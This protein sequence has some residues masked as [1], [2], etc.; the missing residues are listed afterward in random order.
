MLSA[1]SRQLTRPVALFVTCVLI[2]SGVSGV[3]GSSSASTAL[4]ANFA[5]LTRDP[6][7]G[8][9]GKAEL[10]GVFASA[11]QGNP[12][13]LAANPVD[14]AYDAAGQLR[15]VSQTSGG[16]ATGRYNYD[17]AGNL[18][19]I[20]HYD[21]T[22]LSIVSM[23]PS[24][25]SAGASVAISGTA[26]A[27]TPSGNTVKFNGTAATVVSASAV[28][29]VVTVPSG[30]SSGTVTVATSGGTTTSQQ[31][32]T[33]D[34]AAVAPTVT[35]VSPVVAAAG[36]DVTVTGT[37]FDPTPG[38]NNV[39]F[40]HTRARVK[41]A[42]PT[43]LTVTVPDS[44]GAGPVSV[45]TAVG[46]ASSGVKFT[47]VPDK[48][49]SATIAT[50][51]DMTVD[52]AA[53]TV[54]VP[55]AGQK[56][57]LRF[58]GSQGQ[59]LSV[60]FSGVTLADF[61]AVPYSPYGGSFGRTQ[62][63]QGWQFTTTMF[64]AIPLP[65]LPASGIYEV[66]VDPVGSATGSVTATL[67]SRV[68][69]TLN[70]TGAGTTVNLG[71]VQQ[72][73][74]LTFAATAG[75][76]I[77]IG[78][79]GSTFP[80][81]TR[82]AVRLTEPHGA[83]VFWQ[84]SF[85]A[86]VFS[87]D[88]QDLDFT[89]AE[90]GTYTLIIGAMTAGTG[91]ITVTA[92]P[93]LAG[94]ALTLGTA[95]T[96]AINRPG[97]DVRLTF[98]GGKGQVLGADFTAYAFAF[99]PF[100]VVYSPDGSVLRASNVDSPHFDL[101]PLPAD[102]TYQMTLSPYSSTGS[103]TMVLSL[104]G[105]AVP[106]TVDGA[107]VTASIPAAGQTARLAVTTTAA[108]QWVTFAF[109]NYTLPTTLSAQVID[110][111][112]TVIAG[113]TIGSLSTFSVTPATAGTYTLILRPSDGTSTGSV[114]VT[115]SSQVNGGGFT[116][117]AAKNLSAT[118]V[119]QTT[120]Y[121]FTATANQR[122]SLSFG[123][124]AFTHTLGVA[125]VKPDG[126]VLQDTFLTT[127]ELDLGPVP[128][129]G[130]YSFVIHPFAET[131]SSQLTLLNRTDAGAST[132][133]GAAKTLTVS[134]TGWLAETSFTATAGERLSFGFT[135]WT[136][137]ADAVLRIRVIDATG[138]EIADQLTGNGF[139]LDTRVPTAG[140]YRLVL[141]STTFSTGGVA[142]TLSDQ[143][144][145]G[146]ITLASAKNITFGRAG[147]SAWMTYAGT[148]GQS[149]ALTLSNVTLPFYPEV[150][151]I[152]PGGTVLVDN[153]GAPSV[154]IPTLPATG[155]YEIDV[156][157]YSFTG[158]ATFRLGT[159]STAAA[160]PDGHPSTHA[161]DRM[162]A[163]ETRPAPAGSGNARRYVAATVFAPM[164]NAQQHKAPAS[165]LT[166]MGA[167]AQTWMPD[168]RN[169]AGADWDAHLPASPNAKAATVRAPPGVTAL[170][171]RIL[172]VD[173]KPLANITV[174]IENTTAKTD[175]TGQFLLTDLKAGH[176]VLR[177][178][179]ASANTTQSTFGL[180]D[181][182][183]DLTAG[184]TV[185]LP[186]PV[187]LT[188]LDTAHIVHFPS[189]TTAQTI[190]S[191][192]VIPGLQVQLP[193]GAVVRDVHGNVITALGITAIPVDRAPFPLPRS[194]VPVYFTVQPGSSYVFPTGARIVYPNYTHDAPGK[195]M[196][197]WH[198]DP[199]GK[200]WYVYGHGTVT[201]DGGQVVPDNGVEVYQF[202]GAM[203]ITPGE[204]PPPPTGPRPGGQVSDADPVDLGS[205]LLVD[206]HT[207]LTVNDLLPIS[208]A[209]TYQQSDAGHRT[210][211]IGVTSDYDIR[212]F[213]NQRFVEA[214]VVLPDGGKVH[215]RRITP[216]SVAPNDFLNAA[217]A[218]DPTPT[219]FNG[220]ILAW[221]GDGW[222][223]RL[224]NGLTYLFGDEAP[225]RA[226][227]DKFG[228]T[229]TIIRAPA[230]PDSDNIVRDKG[231][232]TQVTSP[233]GHWI[234]FTNDTGNRVTKAEDNSGR[235]VS[236]T[237]DSN[238]RLSTVTDV[239]GGLTTYS[240]DGSGRLSTIKDAR[241]TVYLTNE[242]DAAGRVQK[243]TLA[244][245][246]IYIIS[247][248]TD[249]SGKVTSTSLT[250]PRGHVRRL[251]FN[252]AG[253]ILTDTYAFG[254]TNAQTLTYT[255][256]A[257]SNLVTAVTDALNRQ[258]TYAYDA[259]GNPKT[260]VAMAGTSGAR[261][262]QVAYDGPY[263]QVSKIT[264]PVNHSWT[265]DYKTNG[266][267]VKV[268]DPASRASAV[269]SDE[270]GR[271]TKITDNAG[272]ATLIGY[273][274]G[275]PTSVTDPLGRISSQVLDAAGRVSRQTDPAGSTTSFTWDPRSNLGSATDPL[276]RQT[277]F[278]YDPNGNLHT[279]KD[280]RQNTTTYDYDTS[281][282]LK[283]VTDPL[284]RATTYTYDSNNNLATATDARGKQA[285]YTYDEVDRPQTVRYGVS[286]N[287]QESQIT[288][289]YDL[290]NRL[291]TVAD[292]AGG[293]TTL[294]PDDF[295]NL[296]RV[297]TP[298]GQVDYAYYADNRRQ[299]MTVGGQPTT[300]YTY[301]AD[302]RLKQLTRAGATVTLGYDT[303]GRLQTESLPG[304]VTQTYGYDAA[305]QV[306][307]I[308][309]T[310]NAGTTLGDLAYTFDAAGR[311]I[312][313]GGSYA[314]ADIPAAYG[315]ATYDAANQLSTVGSA[316]YTYDNTG[317]LT[318]DGTTTYTWNARSQLTATARPGL[319]INYGYDGLGRRS[320]QSGG[321][322]TTGYLY[323]GLQPVQELSGST[324]TANLLTGGLDQVFTRTTSAGGNTLLTDALGSTLGVANSSGTV[325]GEYSYQPFGATTLSGT[326]NGNPY[327]FAGRENDGNGLYYNRARYYSPSQQRF[328]GTDPLGIGSG[329]ANPYKYTFNQPTDL[330]DPLGAKPEGSS[331]ES[332]ESCAVNSFTADTP[333]LMADGSHKPIS[334]VKPG[335]RVMAADAASGKGVPQTVSAAIVGSGDKQLVDIQ[336]QAA[337]GT[338]S[339]LT[340]T[341]G[342]LF[343]SDADGRADTPGGR[344]IDA[345]DL[346]HGQWLKTSGGRLV[347]V[348]GT[349][350]RTQHT[351]VYNLTVDSGHT[352]YVVAGDTS[353]LVHNCNGPN[354]TCRAGARTSKA[355]RAQEEAIE[356][357]TGI[358]R[359]AGPGQQSIKGPV[360]GRDRVPD[361]NVDRSIAER[362]TLLESKDLARLEYRGQIRD[363]EAEANEGRGVPLEI[364][365]R[366]GSGTALPKSGGL[367]DAIN[368]E[369]IIIT[370]LDHL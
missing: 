25:A 283:A 86:D 116:I 276:G 240:Y 339:T 273:A 216:G 36:T 161:A 122:L 222:D 242:Y 11:K 16:G 85:E 263:D 178:D 352:Y 172:T 28:R 162:T 229:V 306:T 370:P 145:A 217:F 328:L 111:T 209:R 290:G 159:R 321:G 50:T 341:A 5:D 259:F 361:F 213:S 151:V 139:S 49:A 322:T 46:V 90:T 367:V 23:V 115:L 320:T 136:F 110:S 359:N 175:E 12:L 52:G 247:Y 351:Q 327:R 72:Q 112:G 254:T 137:A 303:V 130:T 349:A 76:R 6:V 363:L 348:T 343:W 323:D 17:P 14:Y 281:D 146:T 96:V 124:Y 278:T 55:T 118:R 134:Q 239:A 228:N 143:Q 158:A 155:T 40:G 39:A 360:T 181:I 282:R 333:V 224:R 249:S 324:P 70:L 44:A 114:L 119:G 34:P 1:L 264:D 61:V 69:G 176:R 268:T 357:A 104:Q 78:V 302:G 337:D 102:G 221:N 301:N 149:L 32:F 338:T 256:D 245:G 192:P 292:T 22:V 144:N 21:S 65:P 206:R 365:V 113:Y 289:T 56:A 129:A 355:G 308:S 179:G 244:D 204:D 140:T 193:A 98:T 105:S 109:T 13:A 227:R 291:R 258:T 329:D 340:A 210:F 150:R 305:S 332:S 195:R 243:Q 274:L 342:H 48:Y 167:V 67:S 30:A 368:A 95:K 241:G 265:F 226:I 45:A 285:V 315:P 82:A 336:V 169:L 188:A 51:A 174:T 294:T 164:A 187:W 37:G 203:L 41:A 200:G 100:V 354:C 171:G 298:Q 317:N 304:P 330:T 318:G 212:L 366:P 284:N 68:P 73:A 296:V 260:I 334:Q 234:K 20:D 156:S 92:S 152:A 251:T 42:T 350:A 141:G 346:R 214:D 117:G 236:Y 196:D 201:A 2:A 59:R 266:A 94:G 186:Y 307:A 358:P 57:I 319:S 154:T 300:T 344:W 356:R 252:P 313:L 219:A 235:S 101:P 275:E 215:Y 286:G 277:S 310:G 26:F 191:T 233:N 345:T 232:I 62:F 108:N 138:L 211:G 362:G 15:G 107:A 142:V 31:A 87:L 148:Q 295:D 77:G 248:T 125:V 364:V 135:N 88:G 170:A 309:Y 33:V 97:Q 202:T 63:D 4:P 168:P 194:Q 297:V 205:G 79:S 288:Y 185:A 120:R 207:D 132:V 9:V 347:R 99:D 189:P 75:Q 184:Q 81:G 106:V 147:Q 80:A 24:R 325:T 353:V 128:A 208:V 19:S 53:T 311:P 257:S 126:T 369:R 71:R 38:N 220:S 35:G 262:T 27:T 199:T 182:G 121:T 237:Y 177:V 66:V 269:D 47:P 223:L 267:L 190:V 335:D 153:P 157:P 89:P 123:S 3:A 271:V 10:P 8:G 225:L 270:A 93:E 314:R 54:S 133:G 255:R 279:V 83:A 287:T 7:L 299:T 198:Y 165:S 197:F 246:G 18:T 230:A 293:T 43:A 272:N 316:T 91:S 166:P 163:R 173:G 180:H 84:D 238:G 261:V 312:H 326:D 253:Y 74:E 331:E 60:G 131:G 231:P 250:D 160:T 280:A 183:V 218:A 58:A 127:T 64:G 29:L 103:L